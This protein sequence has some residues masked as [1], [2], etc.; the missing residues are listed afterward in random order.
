MEMLVL[1]REMSRWAWKIISYVE[2]LGIGEAS[3]NDILYAT[4]RR[5]VHLE[6][7][8]QSSDIVCQVSV[9]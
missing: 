8:A 9:I 3:N 4:H 5:P 7:T 6:M 2:F 1:A